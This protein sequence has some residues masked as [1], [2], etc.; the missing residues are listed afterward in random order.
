MKKIDKFLANSRIHAGSRTVYQMGPAMLA[1]IEVLRHYYGYVPYNWLYG[2]CHYRRT[3][4]PLAIER[5]RPRS[6]VSA[7]SRSG[8]S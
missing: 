7:F 8:F 5:P 3:G 2:Y 4:Q 6:S 1:T